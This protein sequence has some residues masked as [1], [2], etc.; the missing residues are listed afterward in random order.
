MNENEINETVDGTDGT[1]LLDM[2]VYSD[3]GGSVSVNGTSDG[4]G[5]DVQS[6]SSG[7]AGPSGIWLY[8]ADNDVYISL[9]D[10]AVY[11]SVETVAPDYTEAL[12]QID[13]DF[14][15]VNE[16]LI[17]VSDVVTQLNSTVWLLFIFLLITWAEKKFSVLVNRFTEVKERR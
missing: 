1:D 7:D 9:S 14:S 5:E 10:A 13:E 16:T 3:D 6:V 12:V 4:S 15:Q 8:D 17:S 2:S 11:S